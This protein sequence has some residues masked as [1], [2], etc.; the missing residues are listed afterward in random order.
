M[1]RKI[2]IKDN[3]GIWE[4]SE[5]FVI[6]NDNKFILNFENLDKFGQAFFI[7]ELRKSKKTILIEENKVELD[8]LFIKPGTLK[9]Y[10][11]IRE[12]DFATQKIRIDDLKITRIDKD[13]KAVPE[14]KECRDEVA[15]LREKV[16]KL[17]KLT[18]ELTDTL[19]SLL[20]RQIGD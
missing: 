11:E 16:E 1:E 2:I 12:N 4:N 14:I 9:C 20:Q 18:E 10:I 15:Y 7:C 8:E 6:T 13:F 3:F 5:E 17:T 19:M